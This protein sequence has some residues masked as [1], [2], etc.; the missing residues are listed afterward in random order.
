MCADEDAGILLMQDQQLATLAKRP[1]LATA[2]G[3]KNKGGDLGVGGGGGGCVR[4]CV[5]VCVSKGGKYM[6]L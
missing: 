5:C 3:T 2:K 1:G 4:V 6:A